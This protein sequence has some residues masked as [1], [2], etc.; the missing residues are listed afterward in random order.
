MQKA[1]VKQTHVYTEGESTSDSDDEGSSPSE[2]FG[3]LEADFVDEGS[4]F[5]VAWYA[6]QITNCIYSFLPS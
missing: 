6:S 5:T 3:E 2:D 4:Y 1:K